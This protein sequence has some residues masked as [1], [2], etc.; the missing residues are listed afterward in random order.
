MTSGRRVDDPAELDGTSLR[1]DEPSLRVGYRELSLS[2][3]GIGVYFAL[4]V[5]AI[6][7]AN[8]YSGYLI[9]EAVLGQNDTVAKALVTVHTA[10]TDEHRGLRT[11]QDRTSCI[12]TMSQED[13]IRFR[14]RYQSGAFRQECPWVTE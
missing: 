6:I 13:R 1:N 2:A 14:S 10:S 5:A 7:V 11:A 12:L 8:F 9:K 3:R 4:A